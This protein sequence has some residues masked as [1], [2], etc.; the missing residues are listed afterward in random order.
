MGT[1]PAALPEIEAPCANHGIAAD[2]DVVRDTELDGDDPTPGLEDNTASDLCTALAIARDLL[3]GGQ[4]GKPD[5]L[6][7]AR[8]LRRGRRFDNPPRGPRTD[9]RLERRLRG[10]ARAP[11]RRANA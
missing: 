5:L 6:G 8:H 4:A 7:D 3:V 9:A 10:L 1:Q 11:A 2:P